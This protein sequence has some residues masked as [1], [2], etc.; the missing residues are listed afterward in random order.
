MTPL[1]LYRDGN[2]VFADRQLGDNGHV[3]QLTAE[4]LRRERTGIHVRVTLRMD[5]V[6]LSW[7][8]LNIARDQDRLRLANNCHRLFGAR[9]QRSRG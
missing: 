9:E 2:T 5:G 4:S 6:V 7:T 1:A 3:F 8:D